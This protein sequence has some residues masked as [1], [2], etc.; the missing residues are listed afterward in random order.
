GPENAFVH[1]MAEAVLVDAVARADPAHRPL[2]GDGLERVES[3]P[4]E[5][6]FG[7]G[8]ERRERGVVDPAVADD[9]VAA[10]VKLF[11]RFGKV[12]GDPAV[13]VDGA[14][15]AVAVSA[16]MMRQMPAL[17]PYSP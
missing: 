13:G 2:A 14:F 11:Q 12:F 6:F 7:D 10:G 16:S 1:V 5:F 3:A 17:P 9:F 8:V 15:D 4:D